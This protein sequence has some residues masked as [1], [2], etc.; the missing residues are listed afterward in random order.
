MFG[1]DPGKD[2]T[3]SRA[4]LKHLPVELLLRLVLPELLANGQVLEF[5]QLRDL[6][7][8]LVPEHVVQLLVTAV[9]KP[10]EQR[11]ISGQQTVQGPA[12]DAF[13]RAADVFQRGIR[14][15][16]ECFQR[17]F[18]AA[19][20]QVDADLTGARDGFAGFRIDLQRSPRL[21]LRRADLGDTSDLVDVL[22]NEVIR[23]PR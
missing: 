2:F 15:F 23:R 20:W 10:S 16:E 3:G 18:V 7:P 22:R 1:G 12:L 6:V 11:D 21:L 4:R 19:D 9:Q 13:D 8:D 17:A 5:V 14:R